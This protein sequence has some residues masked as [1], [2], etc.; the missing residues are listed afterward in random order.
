[1]N[2]TLLKYCTIKF[3]AWGD[4]ITDDVQAYFSF[5]SKRDKS[6]KKSKKKVLKKS[7]RKWKKS[8]KKSSKK[9]K[10]KVKSARK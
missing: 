6:P 8:L 4:I 7:N 3:V 1:M 2:R 5:R 9:S 10:R